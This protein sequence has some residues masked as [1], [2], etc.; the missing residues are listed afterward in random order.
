MTESRT[1]D[2]SVFLQLM[3]FT[4]C[5][6]FKPLASQLR[7]LQFPAFLY[8]DLSDP[9]GVGLVTLCE[10]PEHIVSQ[11]RDLLSSRLFRVLM[12]RHELTMTG[13]TFAEED[14][15]TGPAAVLAN[16]EWPWAIWYSVRGTTEL[17]VL[18]PRLQGAVFDRMVDTAGHDDADL[19][20]IL[21]KSHGLDQGGNEYVHGLHGRSL[22]GLS[23]IIEAT[24]RS[25]LHAELVASSGPFFVGRLIG[26][27]DAVDGQ[28]ARW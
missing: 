6:D 16:E 8:K 23:A 27:A 1:D 15:D 3:V 25:P 4:D 9:Q 14:A 28:Q 10:K 11:V 2:T 17:S 12:L 13:R 19:G 7:R 20:R 21:L 26:E 5:T 18:D 24:G 22:A